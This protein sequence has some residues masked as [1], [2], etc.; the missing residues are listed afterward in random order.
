MRFGLGVPTGTE[1]MMYP[2][3]YADIDQAVELALTAEQLGFDSVW[4]NDHMST[5]AYVRDEFPDPPNF[6]D[7][8]LYLA[9]VAA[10]T[11][12]LRLATCVTV[13][14]FRHPAVLAK[15]AATLDHLS[16]G[17]LVL[18]VG[19][20][21]YR[22]EFESL[23]P[24]R[25]LHRG[26]YAQEAIEALHLLF[27]QRRS[28]YDGRWVSF[29]DVESYPKPVQQ[30]LPLLSGGNSA[31]SKERAATLGTGWLPACLTPEEVGVGIEQIRGTAEQAGRELPADFDVA[32]QLGVAIGRTREEA[33][34]AFR[35]SQLY[36]HLTS[37][38]ASTLKD[39]AG[40]LESRNLVGTPEQVLEQVERYRH[41][42]VTTLAG[43]LFA[44][45]TIPETTDAMELFS[46]EVIARVGTAV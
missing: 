7:P 22:E 10:R 31:G 36:A 44:A 21:A 37:L 27:T 34:E 35:R 8:W 6:F 32:L 17:R 30:P 1:G 45:R 20:G 14:P 3:P 9:N 28:S 33:V 19:I 25:S 18:G 43:L 29:H 41:A 38:S 24:G 42:G 23:W 39:Q 13:L 11:T 46:K 15:Q 16:H 26:S 4:G 5:Q 40:E 12:T 2:V